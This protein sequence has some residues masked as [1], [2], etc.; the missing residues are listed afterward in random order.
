M[1]NI[2]DNSLTSR[3]RRS[4]NYTVKTPIT[5]S[6]AGDSIL[7]LS[8]ERTTGAAQPTSVAFPIPLFGSMHEVSNYNA[9]QQNIPSGYTFE[10]VDD[11]SNGDKVFKFEQ[12][13][14]STDIHFTVKSATL[15]YRSI[16]IALLQDFVKVSATRL[17]VIPSSNAEMQFAENIVVAS[18]SV[19]G[20]LKS[21]TL[22]VDI[23][24]RPE[25]NIINIIDIPQEFKLDK[26]GVLIVYVNGATTKMSFNFATS[27]YKLG[28]NNL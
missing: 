20:G 21:N 15:A 26:N 9:F 19:F 4:D 3:L 16:L 25:N 14:G 18:K 22:E 11:L 27:N 23:N 6:F 13:A 1:N 5:S 24:Q 28:Q 8:I 17:T 10:G 12:T 2:V 7:S